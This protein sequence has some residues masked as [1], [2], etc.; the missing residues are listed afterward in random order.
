VLDTLSLLSDAASEGLG[1]CDGLYDIN[2]DAPPRF[3]RQD[4]AL[5]WTREVR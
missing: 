5:H 3:R 2:L 1:E 4:P